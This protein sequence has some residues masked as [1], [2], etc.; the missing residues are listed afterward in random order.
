MQPTG[1]KLRSPRVA[2]AVA[3]TLVVMLSAGCATVFAPNTEQAIPITTS[4]RGAEVWVDGKIYGHAPLTVQLDT[5]T[6]HDIT[7]RRGDDIRTWTLKPHTSTYGALW[8]T[9]DAAVLVPGVWCAVKSLEEAQT[10]HYDNGIARVIGIGCLV[11]S[12]PPIVI[13]IATNHVSELEPSEITV[14]YQR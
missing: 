14:D 4:P 8:L 10:T 1:K 7:V 2:F 3:L 5:R 6:K 11:I 9:A 12:V 13:D